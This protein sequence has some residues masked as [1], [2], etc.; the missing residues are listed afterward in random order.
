M[1]AS[2]VSDRSTW[3]KNINQ[4]WPD[5]RQALFQPEFR[6]LASIAAI[7]FVILTIIDVVAGM[8]K[9]MGYLPAEVVQ[10]YRISEQGS[11]AEFAGY[12]ATQMSVFFILVIAVRLRSLLHLTIA[13]LLEYLLLDDMFMLHETIGAGIARRFMPGH[14]LFPPQALG[15]LCFAVLLCSAIVTVLLLVT[16]ASTPY[17]RSLCALLFAPLCLLAFCAIGVDFFHS[18]VPRSAKYLDG[19]VALIEDGGELF[20]MLTLMLIAAAQWIAL[21]WIAPLRNIRVNSP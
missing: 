16:R 3:W 13:G 1:K 7:A 12:F 4:A 14:F 9:F 5:L 21:A 11:L 17:L 6:S 15:E 10:F 19:V 20:A 8:L 18:I 2:S